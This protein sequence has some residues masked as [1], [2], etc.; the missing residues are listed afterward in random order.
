MG[1]GVATS[2]HFPGNVRFACEGK[3]CCPLGGA[4]SS[5]TLRPLSFLLGFPASASLLW[6][7][8]SPVPAEALRPRSVPVGLPS[9]LHLASTLFRSPIGT[10]V[11]IGSRFAVPSP[12]GSG[13]AGLLSES[14]FGIGPRAFASRFFLP[15]P[16]TS[17]AASILADLC[18]VGRGFVAGAF[19]RFRSSAAGHELKLSCFPSR[20]KRIP[21]VDNLYI[22]DK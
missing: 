14:G 12:E 10:A 15:S 11:P 22:G 8:P 4:G 1:A 2:P 9:G 21:P 19:F 20:A 13:S 5:G 17:F 7:V 6:R 3:A 16:S 18:F